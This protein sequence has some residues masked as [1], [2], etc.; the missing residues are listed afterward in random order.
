MKFITHNKDQARKEF[1]KIEWEDRVWEVTIKPFKAKRSHPQK[2]LFWSWVREI[3][4]HLDNARIHI[5][6]NQV[7]QLIV[8]QFGPKEDVLSTTVSVST[9]EYNWD[10]MSDMLSQIQAWAAMDLNLQLKIRGEE[11]LLP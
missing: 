8:Q 6:E 2:G 1:A 5:S 3:K 10:E 9:E 7:K 11:E 4:Q